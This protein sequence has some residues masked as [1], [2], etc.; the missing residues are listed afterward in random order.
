MN[1]V[2][3]SSMM[4]HCFPHIAPYRGGGGGRLGSTEG[5]KSLLGARGVFVLGAGGISRLGVG[6][7]EGLAGAELGGDGAELGGDGAEQLSIDLESLTF[8]LARTCT[9]A[10]YRLICDLY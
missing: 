5:A 1:G 2:A 4:Q 8:S 6:A 3:S 9:R 7:I 10:R